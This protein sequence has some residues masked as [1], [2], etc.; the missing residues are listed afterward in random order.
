MSLS[1]SPTPAP[2]WP[3]PPTYSPADTVPTLPGFSP[4]LN[5]C[6][7][8]SL[9]LTVCFPLSPTGVSH[10]P[11]YPQ[12]LRPR[13]VKTRSGWVGA[14]WWLSLQ[15]GHPPV[16]RSRTGTV[17]SK[18]SPAPTHVQGCRLPT[19]WVSE[20]PRPKNQTQGSR[21]SNVLTFLIQ[22][23]Q[24]SSH[25]RVNLGLFTCD[26][27][28]VFD[29]PTCQPACLPKALKPPTSLTR[30]AFLKFCIKLFLP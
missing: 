10:A 11:L 20:I 25:H 5:S 30:L 15:W 27:T 8:I 4:Y 17:K 12:G 14:C 18:R 22:S 16:H 6:G 9:L 26:T 29:V 23:D 13:A 2:H 24:I 19:L 1:Q 21:Q 28:E 3:G 7:P